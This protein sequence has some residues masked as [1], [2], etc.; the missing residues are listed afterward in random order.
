[1]EFK[2]KLIQ[3]VFLIFPLFLSVNG[4]AQIDIQRY[5]T[6]TDTFYW[7]RYTSI[8]KPLRV[9]LKRFSVSQPG[10]KIDFFLSKQLSQ[11]PQFTNDSVPQFSIRELKKCLYPIDINGDKLPD[12]VFSGFSGGESDIVRI[13]LNRRDSFELVFEDYQ[14]I[15]KFR[16]TGDKLVEMQTGDPGCCANYLYFTRDY[17]VGEEKNEPVFIK[18]KQTVA[19]QYT[20]EPLTYYPLPVPFT[21]RADT[22]LVRASAAQQNEPFNPYLDTFGNIIAKYRSKARG[23]AMAYKSNGKGNDWFFVEISPSVAPSASILYDIDKI[24]TF[25][26]GWVS[27]R[28]IQL[29]Q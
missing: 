19:Y 8:P 18:G 14:Y 12:M 24:P 26:R 6:A 3:V 4:E 17:K 27:G 7:K 28:A 16:K 15:S 2:V 5:T 1:M 23:V 20:E 10:K 11:F 13:W 9:N 25:I 21:A 29:D 22:M